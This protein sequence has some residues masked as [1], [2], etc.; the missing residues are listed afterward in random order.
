MTTVTAQVEPVVRHTSDGLPVTGSMT[1]LRAAVPF[2][3]A[4]ILAGVVTILI[5]V[6]LPAVLAIASASTP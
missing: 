5:M 1:R 4:L 2:I 3:R 6:G